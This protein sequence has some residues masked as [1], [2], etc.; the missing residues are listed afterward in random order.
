MNQYLISHYTIA[1]N[2]NSA[3]D[4]IL[5]KECTNIFD[6]WLKLYIIIKNC[7]LLGTLNIPNI[8][9]SAVVG[10]THIQ[11]WKNYYGQI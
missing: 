2:T 9:V 10:H 6:P 1:R 8:M 11:Y 3:N 7:Q 5:K 4:W